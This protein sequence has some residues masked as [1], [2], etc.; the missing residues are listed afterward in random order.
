MMARSVS[1]QLAKLRKE[2]DALERRENALKER[3]HSRAIEKIKSIAKEAGLTTADITSAILGRKKKSTK[4]KA[5]GDRVK[6]IA[7]SKVAPKYRNPANS[8]QTWTGRGRL[9]EWV[10]ALKSAGELDSALI[11]A[12]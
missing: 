2:R 7:R 6:T 11:K 3:T 12:V 8:T 9:P 4:N 5:I 10:Q 1:A